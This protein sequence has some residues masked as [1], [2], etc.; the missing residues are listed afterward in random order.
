M[1]RD[2]CPE[3]NGQSFWFGADLDP[4]GSQVWFRITS[5]A[6]R[7]MWQETP[8]ARGERLI[9]ALLACMKKPYRQLRPNINC[10]QA[11]VADDGDTWVERLRW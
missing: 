4:D 2:P 11:L 3:P 5:G 1:P 7:R 10:F 8:A 6:V 9:D